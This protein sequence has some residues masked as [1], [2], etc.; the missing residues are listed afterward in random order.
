MASFFLAP[1][2]SGLM[3]FSNGF[4]LIVVHF[5]VLSTGAAKIG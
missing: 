5:A 4:L 2:S 3:N 1:L